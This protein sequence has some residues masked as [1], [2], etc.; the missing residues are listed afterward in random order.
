MWVKLEQ[1]VFLTASWL[2]SQ[3][4]KWKQTQLY[5]NEKGL[6]GVGRHCSLKHHRA[7]RLGSPHPPSSPCSLD[8]SS[9]DPSCHS[10]PLTRPEVWPDWLPASPLTLSVQPHPLPMLCPLSRISSP[11]GTVVRST[12]FQSHCGQVPHLFHVQVPVRVGQYLP[13]RAQ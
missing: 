1:Y 11:A 9:Q 8:L 12:T 2:Q 5:V 7:A 10:T 3:A 13:H 6:L 4:D